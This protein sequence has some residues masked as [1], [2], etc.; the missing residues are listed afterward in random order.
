MNEILFSEGGQPIS[1]DD[2]KSL[3]ESAL[4]SIQAFASIL[5][6]GV[7]GK[8]YYSDPNGRRTLRWEDSIVIARGKVGFLPKGSMPYNLDT[9]YYAAIVEEEGNAQEF[10]D[11]SSHPT[12][13]TTKVIVTDGKSSHQHY[14]KMQRRVG[15]SL[16]LTQGVNF[17]YEK[18]GS[19][20]TSW[21]G[22]YYVL[23]I[24]T[25]NT[26]II[27]GQIRGTFDSKEEYIGI[28][29]DS[30]LYQGED[31][32]AYDGGAT[33]YGDHNLPIGT[34]LVIHKGKVYLIGP[35]GARITSSAGD[36]KIRFTIIRHLDIDKSWNGLQ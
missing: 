10:A 31:L 18:E 11:G 13:K 5:P 24:E 6:D 4:T 21:I 9:D 34:R 30:G 3:Q 16:P 27:Q 28:I 33:V 36:H 15:L 17:I 32:L 1:L 2:I 22:Y 23:N 7:Y 14:A 35:N 8:V 12:R 20:A 26:R 19:F 29:R 25:A